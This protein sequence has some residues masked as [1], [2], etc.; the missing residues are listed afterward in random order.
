MPG[1]SPLA[2]ARALQALPASP[3]PAVALMSARSSTPEPGEL[4]QAGEI[5]LAPLRHAEVL[6]IQ[7]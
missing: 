4:A 2:M 7:H 6:S 5:L 3:K 1:Q